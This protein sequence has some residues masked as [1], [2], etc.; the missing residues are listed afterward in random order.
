ME[1]V[2]TSKGEARA[3]ELWLEERREGTI[4]MFGHAPVSGQVAKA[5]LEKGYIREANNVNTITA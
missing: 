4:A 5:W 3:R 1:Y 2:Y